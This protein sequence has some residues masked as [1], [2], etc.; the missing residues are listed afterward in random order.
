MKFEEFKYERP[1][2]DVYSLKLEEKLNEMD[3]AL[4]SKEFILLF[5]EFNIIRNNISTNQSIASVRYTIDTSNKFYDEENEYWDNIA[6]KY[7][8]F[9]SRLY[10]M[11]LNKQYLDEL[12][13]VIPEAFF[14]VASYSIKAFDEK[15]V[16]LLQTENKLAS[17]YSKL[18]ASCEIHYNGKVYNLSQMSALTT[19]KDRNERKITTDLK[20]NWFKEKEDKID[21]VFDK[22]VKIRT[23]IANEMGYKNY[24]ELGYLRMF[25]FD[26]DQTM[27][28]GFRKQVIESIVPV[29]NE[30]YAK[31]AKRLGLDNLK[32]YDEKYEFASG[33]PTPV[34][35]SD[36]LV[37]KAHT[38]YNEM[39]PETKEFFTLMVDQ[40]LLDL[41]AK[42]KKQGGGYCTNFMD[43]GVPFIFSNFNGTSGDVDVLT[44]EAGHAFQV[45]MSKDI[46]QP[47]CVWPTYE[48]CEIHSMSMEFFAWPWMKSFFEKDCDKYYYLH[49]SSAIKFIPY[50]C[51]VDHF[52]HMVYENPEMT[53]NE[54]KACYSELEKMYLPHKDYEGCEML[55]KGCWWFQQAHIFSTPFYYIDYTLAQICALQFWTRVQNKDENAWNDYVKLCKLGGTKTFATLVDSANLISP[56]KD[57]CVDF[58]IDAIKNA[59]NSIDDQ[60]L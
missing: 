7:Q 53:P 54:R 24:I 59:L 57:G 37:A 34:G 49:L 47:E 11:V 10:K 13:L 26:Y 33:N 42:A 16:D 6:P 8:V 44:H 25:R 52:Q 28:E 31:Q 5:D 58:V 2:F 35:N 15:I 56:F 12:K 3:N 46:T 4:S 19:S 50:G 17:E 39:S 23:K 60:S 41:N 29:A 43:Y 1:D 30:L 45:Y 38:M 9:D 21:D 36:E 55:E 32:Y 27:V 14:K 40:N 22:L 48:S 18:I 51:L 20:M